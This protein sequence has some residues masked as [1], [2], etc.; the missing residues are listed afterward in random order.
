MKYKCTVS[1]IGKNYEGWQSQ[2]NGKT[3]QEV[4]EK[5][6]QRI[7]RQKVDI[8]GSGRTD[9]GVNASAQVFM[10]SSDLHMSA[11]KWMGAINAFL[12]DDIHVLDCVE[13]DDL[14]HARF[15]VRR[16]T[17]TYRIQNGPY[18][19]FNHEYAYQLPYPLDL[20]RM[21]E[22]AQL[23]VG[24][25]DFTSF[26]SSPLSQ[27][28]NQTRTIDDIQIKKDGD[29]ITM[30]FTGKGFLRYQVRMMSAAIID[31]GNHKLEIDEVKN[32]LATRAKNVNRKNAP[33]NGLT[34]EKVAYY[35]MI[36]VNEE[37]QIR[38]FLHGDIIP[39]GY[40]LHQLIEMEER[41]DTD[42]IY[43]ICTRHTQKTIGYLIV[44]DCIARIDLFDLN[45]MKLVNT[46]KQQILDWSRKN[47]IQI[48]NLQR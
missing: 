7:T 41:Q 38:G 45:H 15:Q 26:N 36:A 34:L 35:E 22:C 44:N 48:Q 20:Q 17:Y 30:T 11:Y 8:T 3:I 4:I 40:T 27:Y 16:K 31:V 28:P 29:L 46:V 23:F 14:F 32:M 43:V 10:F 2:R 19:V 12:P 24:T 21:K 18:N 6:L 37:V 42:R 25:H 39:E 47:K 1:Y 33:A 13:V 9:A 5:A